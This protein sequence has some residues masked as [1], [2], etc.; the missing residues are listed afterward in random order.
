MAKTLLKGAKLAPMKKSSLVL[1]LALGFAANAFATPIEITSLIGGA[2]SGT[3]LV[4][5]DELALNNT[6]QW[7][8]GITVSFD[9]SAKAVSGSVHNQ[10]AAPFL[11]GNN[12]LGFGPGGTDQGDGPDATTYLSANTG[13]VTFKFDVEQNYLGLLWGSVDDYNTLA[14]YDG[15]GALIQAFTGSDVTFAANGDQGASGTFR[16]SFYSDVLF[17]T[18]IATSTKNSFEIDNLAFSTA[19]RVPDGGA[20]IALLGL[21]LLA[22]GYVRRN[23]MAAS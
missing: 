16:V 23:R 21:A 13:S 8:N 1:F 18:V 12:G 19:N 7:T 20:T 10:Y 22:I 6:T 11:S 9:G 17:K 3:T 15:T 14:F 2:P 5:F 4:N